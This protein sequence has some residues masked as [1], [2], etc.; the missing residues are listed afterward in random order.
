MVQIS[1][2]QVGIKEDG[3]FFDFDP[4]E[5]YGLFGDVSVGLHA[6]TAFNSSSLG[7]HNVN[8]KTKNRNLGHKGDNTNL[9]SPRTPISV[10]PKSTHLRVP[11]EKKL[12]SSDKPHLQVRKSKAWSDTEKDL[13]EKGLE[14]FGTSWSRISNFMT[15]KTASQV[16]S[17]HKKWVEMANV[18]EESEALD[19]CVFMSSDLKLDSSF[20][21]P[22]VL[23]RTASD[24]ASNISLKEEKK[25][26]DMAFVHTDDMGISCESL[27]FAEEWVISTENSPVIA[28]SHKKKL[29]RKNSK[30]SDLTI[31]FKNKSVLP[32]HKEIFQRKSKKKCKDKK[33]LKKKQSSS[34]EKFVAS[35]ILVVPSSSSMTTSSESHLPQLPLLQGAPPG[36]LGQIVHLSKDDEKESDV[37]I[38]GSGDENFPTHKEPTSSDCFEEK[39]TKDIAESNQALPIHEEKGKEKENRKSEEVQK[40]RRVYHIRPPEQELVMDRSIITDD[41][42]KIHCEYF[43]GRS[44]KTPER[45]IKIRN[46]LIDYWNQVK[47]KYIR[48]TNARAGLERCGD[49]NSIGKIHEYLEKIGAI[50]FGCPESNYSDPLVIETRSKERR[51]A[52][53]KQ[54]P[55]LDRS[56]MARQKHKKKE[57]HMSEGGGLTISHDES[58]AVVDAYHVPEAPKNRGSKLGG[59]HSQFKLIRCL[60]YDADTPPPFHV[61]IHPHALVVMDLHA[62]TS[63]GEVMGLLG[64]YH[65]PSSKSLHIT[66]CVPTKATSSGVE[67]DMCPISQI[68]ACTAIQERGVSVVGWYHSHPTFLPNPSLQDLDT[69]AEMQQ[70]FARQEAPFVGIIISP[71]S[72]TNKDDSSQIRCLILGPSPSA[73]KLTPL[74]ETDETSSK[75]STPYKLIWKINDVQTPP[76]AWQETLTAVRSVVGLAREDGMAVKWRKQWGSMTFWEKTIASIA[77]HLT[78]HLAGLEVAVRSTL[79]SAI[80]EYMEL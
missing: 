70:W 42:K 37:D 6:A 54:V 16:R 76:G 39:I 66:V 26:D 15:T 43:L 65:D 35:Q 55:K 21:E 19:P 56:D 49:V 30:K 74:Q 2:H 63:H 41:E 24:V 59:R 69:Q 8:F 72:L 38:D 75:L 13:F 7:G 31:K 53:V 3:D 5:D 18:I 32:E 9:C 11:Q 67:C 62:H 4:G 51:V 29:K 48:K 14:L 33:R 27:G 73:D 61:V 22:L 80:R 44:V 40:S 46:Y 20:E 47:P 68:A 77:C 58:G 10:F 57:V 79:L 64:G 78:P 12:S 34:K 28:D 25:K 36:S 1:K 45:Y 17:Y 23:M 52:V 50:N 71:Y 60:N